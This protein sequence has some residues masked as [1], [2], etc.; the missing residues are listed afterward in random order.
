M[1]GC[2]DGLEMDK[3]ISYWMIVLRTWFK[4]FSFV[5]VYV[6]LRS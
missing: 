5:H 2:I 4:F 1:D 3:W 6:N